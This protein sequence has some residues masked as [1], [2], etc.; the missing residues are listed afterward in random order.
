MVATLPGD[1]AA[2][3]D[4]Y[5]PLADP[6]NPAQTL[7]Q[8]I[9]GNR[10]ALVAAEL[11]GKTGQQCAQRWRHTTASHATPHKNLAHPLTPRPPAEKLNWRFCV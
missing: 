4:G 7:K 1:L 10:W 5:L 11:P 8:E 9:C 6:R 3:M 2:R